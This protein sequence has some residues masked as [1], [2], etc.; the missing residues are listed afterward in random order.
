V[1]DGGGEAAAAGAKSALGVC[2]HLI[3]N[4][5][6]IGGEREAEAAAPPPVAKKRRIAPVAV[7]AKAPPASD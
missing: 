4:I 3:K 6:G 2:E 1:D 5:E 7:P